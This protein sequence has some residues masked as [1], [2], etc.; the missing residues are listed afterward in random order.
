MQDIN[1]LIT[2]SSK[3]NLYGLHPHVILKFKP[4]LD[5]V[6]FMKKYPNYEFDIEFDNGIKEKFKFSDFTHKVTSDDEKIKMYK[7]KY[8]HTEPELCNILRGKMHKFG[9]MKLKDYE[10]NKHIYKGKN[11]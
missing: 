1:I 9:K 2:F 10:E 6:S 11:I 8:P 4:A 7:L 3:R 5:L